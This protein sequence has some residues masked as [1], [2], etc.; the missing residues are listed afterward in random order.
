MNPAWP[1]LLHVEDNLG[2][3]QLLEHAC[4]AAQLKCNLDW[5]EDGQ[6]AVDF[7]SGVGPYSDRQRFLLPD[8]MLLDLKMP[9]KNGFEVL[10]WLRRQPQFKWLPIVIFTASD[11]A[12]DILRAL[13]LGANSVLV[14][15]TAYRDLV[16]CATEL[17]HYWFQLCRL[18]PRPH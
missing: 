8:L 5:V 16:T 6:A 7:L 1:T 9:R 14:K 10:E 13:E 18:P 11:S 12:K 4:R 3:K 17:Y 15:P 2:D